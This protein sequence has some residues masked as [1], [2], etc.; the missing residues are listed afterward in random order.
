[1]EHILSFRVYESKTTSGLTKKQEDFLNRYT[2]GTWIVN[3]TTG[4]VDI[5]GIFDFVN[6]GAKSFFGVKFG[7]V[8]RNFYCYGNKLQS[9]AG[10]P[11]EVGG[12]FYCSENQLQSLEGAPKKVDGDFH[13]GNN[14]LQSLVGAPLEVG[15]RF[16]CSK[17]QLQSLVGSPQEVGGDFICHKNNLQSLAGAPKKVNGYFNCVYNNLQSL[18]GAPKEIGGKFS[19]HI[20]HLGQGKW[21]MEGWLEVLRT[22]NEEAKKLILTLPILNPTYWNSKISENPESTIL[23]LSGF[24]DDLP[25]N[26]KNSIRIPSNLKDDFENLLDLVRKGIM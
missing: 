20:F 6:R 15:G 10:A 25:D 4:L 17:N 8:T 23:E 7:N 3:P 12:G 16:I 22:G 14:K 9:L 5:Q 13:C 26:I 21:N 19:C 1:M 11:R 18:E 2:E 24:W